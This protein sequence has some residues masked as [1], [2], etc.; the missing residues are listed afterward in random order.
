VSSVFEDNYMQRNESK[1]LEKHYLPKN[2]SAQ[3]AEPCYRKQEVED[4]FLQRP[5]IAIEPAEKPKQI[6]RTYDSQHSRSRSVTPSRKSLTPNK[7]NSPSHHSSSPKKH[8]R[9][10]SS[11]SSP[12]KSNLDGYSRH[13]I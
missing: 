11:N 2:F 5:Q 8:H 12:I 6:F 3:K 7:K 4:C 9:E 13:D 1:A 10:N